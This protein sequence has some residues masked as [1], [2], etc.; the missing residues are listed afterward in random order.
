MGYNVSEG[1]LA[2]IWEFD[3]CEGILVSP[4]VA[5]WQWLAEEQ[6]L[7]QTETL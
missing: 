7:T 1:G 5:L 2:G 3:I 6:L 4:C